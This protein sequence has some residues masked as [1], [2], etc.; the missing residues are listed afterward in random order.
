MLNTHTEADASTAS[1]SLLQQAKQTMN[2]HEAE[3]DKALCRLS[4]RRARARE[5]EGESGRERETAGE[6]ARKETRKRAS[7]SASK[8]AS[9]REGGRVSVVSLT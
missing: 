1:T 2:S 5:R 8:R 9:E 3:N 4:K 7:K 6:R